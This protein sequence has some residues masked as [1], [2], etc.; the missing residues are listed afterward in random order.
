MKQSIELK[1]VGN[2]RELGGYPAAG[3]KRVRHGV[4][5]RTAGM[6]RL[7]PED[8]QR[9][10]KDFHVTR[11]VDLRTE[12]EQR[13]QPD[14]AVKGAENTAISLM[15][16]S[17]IPGVTE[18]LLQLYLDT[19]ERGNMLELLEM[20]LEMDVIDESFYITLL[21]TRRGIDGYRRFFRLLLETEEGS[22]FLWHC[23]DGKDRTGIAAMLIL[24]ALGADRETITA[25]YL[26]TNEYNSRQLAMV[27]AA[28]A[29]RELTEHQRRMLDFVSGGVAEEFLN[30][31]YAALEERYGSVE[32]YM[33]QE[34]GVGAAE[35]EKLRRMFLE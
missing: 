2:A 33:E 26:L 10:E 18:E 5:L 11:V 35:R 16:M 14:P 25:D 19:R 31:A 3:G 22:A 21:T 12:D 28:F 6:V 8:E 34:L 9:L 4:L 17:D 29:K 15:E 1:S 27:Q 23:T 30:N 7:S 32:A 20:M 24:T 13:L